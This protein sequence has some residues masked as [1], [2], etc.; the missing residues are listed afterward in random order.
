M[1]T[2]MTSFVYNVEAWQKLAKNPEDRSIP[3]KALMEKLGGRLI[4]MYYMAGDYDGVI[5]YEA[6]D[7]KV[8]ATAIIAAG[9]PGHIRTFKTSQLYTVAETMEVVGNAGKLAFPA[10]KG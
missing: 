2:Y 3:V 8:A 10:P 9:L 4:S 6:P 1:P 7:A 5:I